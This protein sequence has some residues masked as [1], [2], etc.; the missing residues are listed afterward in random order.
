MLFTNICNLLVLEYVILNPDINEFYRRKNQLFSLTSI[1]LEELEFILNFKGKI[2]NIETLFVDN[3]KISFDV[4]KE[5]IHDLIDYLDKTT[6]YHLITEYEKIEDI[7][8]ILC[9]LSINQSF[10]SEDLI[11]NI[12]KEE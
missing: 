8:N 4:Y 3:K 9:D 2:Y 11:K 10:T 1:E 7:P 5:A 6:S 12:E